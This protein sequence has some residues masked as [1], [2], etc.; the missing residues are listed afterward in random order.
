[1]GEYEKPKP[2]KKKPKAVG[3]YPLPKEGTYGPH[4][5]YSPPLQG[6]TRRGTKPK[7]YAAYSGKRGENELSRI[8][9]VYIYLCRPPVTTKCV[10]SLSAAGV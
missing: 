1:M 2:S 10:P 5:S 7:V 9:D 6:Y 4:P 3:L 8:D